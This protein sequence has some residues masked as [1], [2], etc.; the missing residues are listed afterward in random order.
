MAKYIKAQKTSRRV[1][2]SPNTLP[3]ADKGGG[4]VELIDGGAESVRPRVRSPPHLAHLWSSAFSKCLGSHL[5]R[6]S[7]VSIGPG[8]AGQPSASALTVE[9]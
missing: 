6:C 5:N 8:S 1:A 9:P 4:M 3:L 2:V 7:S